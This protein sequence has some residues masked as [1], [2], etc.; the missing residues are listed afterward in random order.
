MGKV[1]KWGLLKIFMSNPH[2]LVKIKCGWFVKNNDSNWLKF[3]NFIC[4]DVKF[5]W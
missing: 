4:C 5:L 1:K 3:V 2:K